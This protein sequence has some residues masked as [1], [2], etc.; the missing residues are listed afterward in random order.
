MSETLRARIG[1]LLRERYSDFGATLATEKL[2][3]LDGLK[4]TVEIGDASLR[5]QLGL[6]VMYKDRV[7]ALTAF[8][9]KPIPDAA[10]G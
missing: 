1:S 9:T 3:E 4:V 2:L 7:L 10:G 6:R 5:R 8:G